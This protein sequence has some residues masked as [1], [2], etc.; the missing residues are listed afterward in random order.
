M[1]MLKQIRNYSTVEDNKLFWNVRLNLS[2]NSI[3][4]SLF[5]ILKYS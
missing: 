2:A 1:K 4:S 5:F 3:N